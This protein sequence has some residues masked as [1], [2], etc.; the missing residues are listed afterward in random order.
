M[1]LIQYI[2]KRRLL[3]DSRLRCLLQSRSSRTPIR[4]RAQRSVRKLGLL[5]L[6][7]VETYQF[8]MMAILARRDLKDSTQSTSKAKRKRKITHTTPRKKR[9]KVKRKRKARKLS[10]N[11][12]KAKC[13]CKRMPISSKIHLRSLAST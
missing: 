8:S 7:V 4:M 3:K 9:I 13:R 2:S 11:K 5:Y 12:L 6:L 1:R 10:K